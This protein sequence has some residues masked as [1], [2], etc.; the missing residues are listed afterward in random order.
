MYARDAQHPSV[1]LWLV[2]PTLTSIRANQKLPVG[3]LRQN[4]MGHLRVCAASPSTEDNF[5]IRG[6]KKGYNS[7]PTDSTSICSSSQTPGSGRRYSTHGCMP[8]HDSR[9]ASGKRSAPSS[10]VHAD[11][12]CTGNEA[13]LGSA[14]VEAEEGLEVSRRAHGEILLGDDEICVDVTSKNEVWDDGA[15]DATEDDCYVTR[16]QGI[17]E[18]RRGL[19]N[20]RPFAWCEPR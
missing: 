3:E 4:L 2:G 11:L 6:S 7:I 15:T 14:R 20:W 18:F 16:C 13:V 19:S 1:V 10:S 9:H 8:I 17:E 5:F 12:P